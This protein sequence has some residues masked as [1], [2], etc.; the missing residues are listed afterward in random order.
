MTATESAVDSAGTRAPRSFPPGFL[1]G[2]S[3][4]AYQIEGAA[5]EDGRGPSIW[6]TFSHTPSKIRAADTGDVAADHYHR[7][8]EDVALMADLGIAAYRFSVAWPRIQPSGSGPANKA[9]LDF[10][11]R[12]VDALL[13]RGIAPAV[14]LYHW[15]LPQ[16]LEDKGG[17]TNRDTAYRFV[18]Y[19]SLV[20]AALGDRV[21]LWS[22]LNEPWCSA[23]LGYGT[24]A[25]AP[26]RTDPSL[27][28]A[29]M[30]HLLL[31]HGLATR[32]MRSASR[33]GQ[34]FSV[35]L[36]LAPVLPPG[37]SPADLDAARRIDGLQN[38]VFLHPVLRGRYPKD[39]VRD[40]SAV[41]DWS[42][43]RDGDE[44][45]IGAP[46]DVLG[47]NYYSPVRVA[48]HPDAPGSPAYP[49]S[50]GVRVLVPQG[51]LSAMGWEIAPRGLT[52][53]LVR[54][55][56]DYGVPLLITENGAAFDD[57]LRPDGRVADPRRI[58][59]LE[60]HFRAALAA[61]DR[62]VDLRGYFVWSLM[63][64]FE[65]AEG[66]GKRFGLVYIDYDSQ[67]RHPK[68]SAWWFRGVIR[69]NAL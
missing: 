60:G 12:L 49:A 59:F 63:D 5:T 6:D 55:H 58:A 24:G 1:W 37:N 62:G 13:A 44:Q 3:T 14:T 65:W 20:H 33:P 11:K 53:L 51:E 17:W 9:G 40:T 7:F 30:H 57:V 4:A 2:V 38:R 42:F 31:G 19:A 69:A 27:A 16:T 41:S 43:V 21:G 67:T 10:Y 46:L 56:E 68:D 66:Y 45:T 22:T 36:N 26:G 8:G 25:H 39:V 34:Q 54:L 35:T 47:V 48:A 32:A 29:A 28:L 61:I 50:A 52:E 64:N 18:E 15:D 23:F